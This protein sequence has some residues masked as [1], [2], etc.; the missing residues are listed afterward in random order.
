VDIVEWLHGLGLEKY[1]PAFDEN[2]I[3]WDFMFVL[4]T[5]RAEVRTQAGFVDQ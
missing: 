5:R 2:A 1:A 4:R 3:N